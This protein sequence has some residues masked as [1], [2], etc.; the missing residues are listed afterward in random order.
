MKRMSRELGPITDPEN[1]IDPEVFE[2]IEGEYRVG[3]VTGVNG[4]GKTTTTRRLMH[5]ATDLDLIRRHTTK[6][7]REG[8]YIYD[9]VTDQ[10]FE[11]MLDRDE[12]VEAALYGPGY[13]GTSTVETRR[14]M[15]RSSLVI[16]EMD[17]KASLIYKARMR[18][19][20]NVSVKVYFLNPFEKD[21]MSPEEKL[22]YMLK[23]AGEERSQDYE[24]SSR[25]IKSAT[26]A[27]ENEA[28]DRRIAVAGQTPEEVAK[29]IYRDLTS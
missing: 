23:R 19:I 4:A 17:P 22:E 13:Y 25:L 20:G 15:G 5:G 26:F 24:E 11:S 18:N 21:G 16:C 6:E 28:F 14:S 9:Q 7:L 12:F 2:D 27:Y 8:D 29:T 1:A 10:V 3:I